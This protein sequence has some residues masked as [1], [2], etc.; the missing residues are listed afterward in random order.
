M[1]ALG[2]LK[3]FSTAEHFRVGWR[4]RRQL[5][6]HHVQLG[7]RAPGNLDGHPGGQ[8]GLLGTVGDQQRTLLGNEVILFFSLLPCRFL[9]AL[10][11]LGG[12]FS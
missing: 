8:I 11:S 12:G 9:H 5:D 3:V 7:A 10:L 1:L 4:K 2:L 6:V